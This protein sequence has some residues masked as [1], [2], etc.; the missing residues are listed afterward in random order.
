MTRCMVQIT[1]FKFVEKIRGYT[2]PGG[3][4]RLRRRGA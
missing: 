4:N 2:S 1:S 3:E